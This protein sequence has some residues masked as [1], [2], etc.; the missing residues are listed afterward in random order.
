MNLPPLI[1]AAQF[2]ASVGG[3]LRYSPLLGASPLNIKPILA[4]TGQAGARWS[5]TFSAAARAPL[6]H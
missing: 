3:I 6:H 2:A 5:T 1:G 4:S